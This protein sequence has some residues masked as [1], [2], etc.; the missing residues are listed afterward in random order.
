MLRVTGQVHRITGNDK[1]DGHF[2]T[3]R[4]EID[5]AAQ[6]VGQPVMPFVKTVVAHLL[7]QQAIA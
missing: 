6:C 7:A 2:R 3:Q 4:S 5:I 1:A